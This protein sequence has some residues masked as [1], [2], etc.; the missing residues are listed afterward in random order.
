MVSGRMLAR[1]ACLNGGVSAVDAEQRLAGFLEYYDL[2]METRE[3]EDAAMKEWLVWQ[4]G[5]AA[6]PRSGPAGQQ[7]EWG[8][9]GKH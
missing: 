2:P 8:N 7:S 3:E 4:S 6:R 9:Y 1:L 5:W